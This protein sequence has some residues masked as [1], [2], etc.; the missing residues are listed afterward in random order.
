MKTRSKTKSKRNYIKP[1][2]LISLSLVAITSVFLFL[3]PATKFSSSEKIIAINSNETEKEIFLN[4]LKKDSVIGSSFAFEKTGN[5]INLWTKL[6]PGKYKIKKK[7]EP[8]KPA[9]SIWKKGSTKKQ[10]SDSQTQN[11]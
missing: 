1:G 8:D 4:K 3:F 2:I 7:C 11:P 10:I 5:V 6:K 9:S